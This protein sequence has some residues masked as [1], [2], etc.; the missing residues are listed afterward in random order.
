MD[1]APK[2][3]RGRWNSLDAV[4]SFGWSGSALVGGYVIRCHGFDAVFL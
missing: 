2:S 4:T 3:Q 1:Y